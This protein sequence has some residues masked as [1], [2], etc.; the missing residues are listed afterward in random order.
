MKK[1]IITILFVAELS[2]WAKILVTIH[3]M[4]MFSSK[5]Y[6][7][8]HIPQLPPISSSPR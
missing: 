5:K 7:S 6:F 1:M 2:S 3:C 4:D 8:I